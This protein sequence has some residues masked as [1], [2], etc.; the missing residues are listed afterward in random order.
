MRGAR[1]KEHGVTQ[2]LVDPLLD[3]LDVVVCL[4]ELCSIGTLTLMVD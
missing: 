1:Q 2:L 4:L 3:V